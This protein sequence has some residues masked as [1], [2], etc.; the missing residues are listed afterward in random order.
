MN[1]GPALDPEILAFYSDRYEEDTRLRRTAH[2]RLEMLRTREL[3]DRFLP[4]APAHVVDVGGATGVHARWLADAGHTVDLIDPVPSHVAR[5]GE[6]PGVRARAGDARALPFDDASADVV[7]LLG[8]LYHLT[9]R[10]DRVLALREA[11]RVARPG[12]LVVAAAISRYAGLL[13]LAALG[14]VSAENEP[15][16]RR[17]LETGLHDPRSGFTTAY[18]HLPEELSGE[19]VE[20]GLDAVTVYGVE[21]PSAPALDNL[22]LDQAE[23]MLGSAIRAARLLETDPAMICASP[24]FLAVGRVV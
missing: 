5:A 21:G 19:L 9:E 13:E 22:P 1:T 14:E 7:L 17:A 4:A 23:P 11:A 15:S 18:F 2:G 6:I 3:L 20:A 12:G 8:P 10:R 16:L 24:H